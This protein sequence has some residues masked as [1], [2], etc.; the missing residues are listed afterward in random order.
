MKQ[1]TTID[2]V[3]IGYNDVSFSSLWNE[4]KRFD[5]FC[6]NQGGKFR[7]LMLESVEYQ[8]ERVSYGDLLNHYFGH[9]NGKQSDLCVSKLPNLAT[10]YLYSYLKKRKFNV[11]FVNFF[12][13][14]KQRLA[15]LLK[16][17][18]KSVAI[19]TT[20]YVESSPIIEIVRF[21]RQHN[22][23]TT[24]IVGGPHVYNLCSL[25]EDRLTLQDVV[26]QEIGADVYVNDSQGELTLSLILR[27]LQQTAPD[28]RSI[29]N[30][31]FHQDGSLHRTVRE[32]EN[33][34]LDENVIDWSYFDRSFITPI[35]HM[36]TARSCAYKCAFCTFPHFAGPLNLTSLDL[37]E[38]EL[39]QLADAGVRHVIFT[40]D[41]FN[42]PLPRFKQLCQRMIDRQFNFDWF[43]FFRCS[44]TDE[45]TFDLMQKSGC[46]AVLLGIESGD[47]TILNNMNKKVKIE[48]YRYGI[49]K[50]KE[51]GIITYAS[52]IMGFPGETRETALNTLHFIEETAPM[53][54]HIM[55]YFHY[56]TTPI[57]K[58]A[59]EY[60]IQGGGYSWKHHTM[61][62]REACRLIE[63]VYRTI[64]R[65][66]IIPE[67]SFGGFWIL[68]YLLSN[69]ISLD[70]IKQFL[71]YAQDLLV[72]GLREPLES[73]DFPIV[74]ETSR[75]T[76]FRGADL[77][78]TFAGPGSE[79]LLKREESVKSGRSG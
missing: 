13:K 30:V 76:A 67:Q 8:G 53:F 62:Y 66:F 33:N 57:A 15:S 31:L 56:P 69:G 50:L 46:R 70:E 39:S 14:E 12:T 55:P 48:R 2:C 63:M 36:R 58:Q 54:Y 78:L 18:T 74:S 77:H 5:A 19:T 42:V 16:G 37:V 51:R 65:S 64:T 23:D 34:S 21:I 7:A 27:E 29:P 79:L 1:D 49:Q 11:E 26:L 71:G 24:I 43:S 68:A 72:K 59:K 45:E 75:R 52:F 73:R 25:Y 22:P 47:Q 35:V 41:T 28:F 10:C 60:G 40:D 20:F 3:L 61:D 38:R 4:T 6:G 9:K 44:N 17:N 32:P